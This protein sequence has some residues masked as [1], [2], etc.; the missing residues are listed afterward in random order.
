MLSMRRQV[1]KTM[2]TVGEKQFEEISFSN[3]VNQLEEVNLP[4][5]LAASLGGQSLTV[6]VLP[7]EEPR[8]RRRV[9]GGREARHSGDQSK[10]CRD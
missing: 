3:D 8:T 10:G 9:P 7:E 6:E 5:D 4:P 1:K 2:L